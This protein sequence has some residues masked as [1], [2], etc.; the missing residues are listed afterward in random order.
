MFVWDEWHRYRAE[1]ANRRRLLWEAL[2]ALSS[3][4]LALALL[5]FKWVATRLGTLGGESQTQASP[6]EEKAAQDIGWAVG[7]LA[8]RVP[9]DSRC[10]AQAIAA[11]RMLQRRGIDATVYFGV[12]RSHEEAFTAHAWLRCGSCFVTGGPGHLEYRV[13]TQFSHTAPVLQKSESPH[14][15]VVI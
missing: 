14:G 12:K 7:V 3:A 1:P 5:R 11:Y 2:F 15:D 13:L 10:L 6:A 4:R 8:P 9:W